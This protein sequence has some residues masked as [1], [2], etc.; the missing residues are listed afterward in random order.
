MRRGARHLGVP[1]SGPA[2]AVSMALAN[3]LVGGAAD[4]TA[5]EIALGGLTA[6]FRDD[7]AFAVA[8][9]PAEVRLNDAPVAQHRTHAARSG[10]VLAVGRLSFGAR[11]YLAVAGGFAADA[12]LGSPSTYAPAGFGGLGGRRLAADDELTLIAPAT[13]VPRLRTPEAHRPVIGEAFALRACASAETGLLDPA[14]REALFETTFVVG[15]R[16]DRMGLALEGRP[17]RLASDGKMKS[18][19]VF[20]GVVQCPENGAPFALLADAQ[21]TGGYPRV[22]SVARC[23]RHVLG[24]L[25]PGA[26]VRLLRRTREEAVDALRD[27]LAFLRAWV[28][29]IDLA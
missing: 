11:I 7:V 23:D 15:R 24:Q 21:T 22:A 18:A 14:S 25:R 8:G 6:R 9:A 19:A 5:L 17:L 4:Q 12:F 27:K 20:P 16:G 1:W 28:P 26:R 10:D 3:R 29:D 2:D 13:E